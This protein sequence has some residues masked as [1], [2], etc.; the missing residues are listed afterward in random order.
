VDV[1]PIYAP[2]TEPI[3]VKAGRWLAAFLALLFLAPLLVGA[4]LEPVPGGAGTH[5]QL[6]LSPCSSLVA[7]DFPCISC[8]MT[9]SVT[10]F[11]H[12][13]WLASLYVQPAGFV[14]ALVLCAAFWVAAY[15]AATGRPVHRLLMGI[16][17]RWSLLLMSA[18]V[19]GGWGWKIYIHA[20]GLDGW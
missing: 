15:I 1:P 7:S 5:L 17:L 3:R 19:L 6:G 8:G 16:S 14:F 18:T 4:W 11:A 12:G 13:N 20:R 10:Y 2:P 9:T